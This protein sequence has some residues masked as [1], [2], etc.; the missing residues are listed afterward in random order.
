MRNQK[1]QGNIYLKPEE[2]NDDR[3]F[4]M[5]IV[6]YVMP[7]YVLA[8]RYVQKRFQFLTTNLLFR[9]SELPSM[10]DDLNTQCSLVACINKLCQDWPNPSHTYHLGQH[11]SDCP[12]YHSQV[13]F[14]QLQGWRREQ[15]GVVIWVQMVVVRLAWSVVVGLTGLTKTA[16]V[17]THHHRRRHHLHLPRCDDKS[18]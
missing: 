7:P 4:C 2:Y 8:D 11:L 9:G 1:F 18:K 10:F 6:N 17:G 15:F 13:G 16:L 3:W 5:V 12:C 14:P